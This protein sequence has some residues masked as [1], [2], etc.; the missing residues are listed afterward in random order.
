VVDSVGPETFTFDELVGT[1]RR[2]VRSSSRV[3]HLPAPVAY[4]ATRV[5]GWVLG[6]V[7]LTWQEYQGLMS[8]LLASDEPAT[9][10]TRLS[11]WLAQNRETVGI[12]Y[13][14]EVA[15]HF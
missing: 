7:V 12:R 14:S 1:I 13:A 15:R 2:E 6:D 11:A 4:V 5:T 3:I 8:N 10:A 9:G